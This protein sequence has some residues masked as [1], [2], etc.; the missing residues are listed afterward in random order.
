MQLLAPVS[1]AHK[2]LHNTNI[3]FCPQMPNSKPF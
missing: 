2:G 1:A 3:L